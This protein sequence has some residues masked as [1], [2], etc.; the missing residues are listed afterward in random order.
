MVFCFRTLPSPLFAG[1]NGV[2]NFEIYLRGSP[3]VRQVV[4]GA[5]PVDTMVSVFNRLRTLAKV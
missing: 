1:V 5:Q 4:S 2:P 3:S